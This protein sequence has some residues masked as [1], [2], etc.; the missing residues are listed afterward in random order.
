VRGSAVT[1]IYIYA[2]A[3]DLLQTTLNLSY[4][5]LMR[6]QTYRVLGERYSRFDW[7]ACQYVTSFFL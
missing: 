1:V 6:G 3:L 7:E 2:R 5:E 4:S